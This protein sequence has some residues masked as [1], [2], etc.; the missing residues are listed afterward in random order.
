MADETKEFV[1]VYP[2]G[3]KC[4]ATTGIC[5]HTWNGGQCCLS[6]EDDETFLDQVIEETISLL[7]GLGYFIDLEESGHVFLLGFSAGAV[8]SHRMA[9]RLSGKISAIAAVSGTLNFP[10]NFAVFVYVALLSL[11]RPLCND[12]AA[13]YSFQFCKV[14]KM[15]FFYAPCAPKFGLSSKV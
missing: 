7:G 10:G 4:I 14:C 6:Y 5:G 2:L 3:S 11:R 15:P 1:S 12:A 9:C 8:M 13:R